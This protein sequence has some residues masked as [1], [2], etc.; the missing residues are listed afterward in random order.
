MNK[1]LPLLFSTFSFGSYRYQHFFVQKGRYMY[2]YVLAYYSG[3][4]E[5]MMST[6]HVI[7]NQQISRKAF[8]YALSGIHNFDTIPP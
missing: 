2:L 6:Y 1:D 5:N 7:C 3:W 4:V 8:L